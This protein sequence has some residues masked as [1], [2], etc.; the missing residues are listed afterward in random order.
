MEIRIISD[1]T[2][3][4]TRVKTEDGQM[5]HGVQKVTWSID[6]PS[7]LARAVLTF[8]RVKVDVHGTANDE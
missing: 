7:E 6:G 8:D 5:V 4:G 1:G 2:G 3:R